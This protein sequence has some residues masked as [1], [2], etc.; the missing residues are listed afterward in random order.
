[1][2]CAVQISNGVKVEARATTRADAPFACP[3]C[4]KEVVI[5]KGHIRVHHFA[6][7]PPVT[8][9]YGTGES[10]AHRRCK[11]AIY[12]ELRASDLA[13]ACELEKDFGPVVAD[14]YAVISRTPVAIEVQISALTLEEIITRT[15][16]YEHLGISL[17]WLPQHSEA[18]ATSRYAPRVWE[19]WLHAAYFGRVYYWL[20]GLTIL[21]VHFSHH[22]L[23]VEYREWYSEFG[24]LQTAGGFSRLSRRWC[25]PHPGR[26]L[27]L[28]EDF[29]RKESSST[30]VGRFPLPARNLFADNLAPWWR[31]GA[32]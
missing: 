23:D 11:V 9:A 1:M 18:I 29:E 12:D 27:R 28:T 10:E 13:S 30:K 4:E 31:V 5:R 20:E 25:R 6:H 7:K 2:L 17:L 8:C 19:R 24:E 21:P 22:Y 26:R 16:A 14:V 3:K 15:R 32:G